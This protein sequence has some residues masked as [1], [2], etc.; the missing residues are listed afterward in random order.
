MPRPTGGGN[1]TVIKGF[2]S[3]LIGQYAATKTFMFNPPEMGDT[4]GTSWGSLEVPGASHPIQQ[5]GAGGERIISFT[6][7]VDGDRGNLGARKINTA[8][9]GDPSQIPLDVSKEL[10]TYRSLVYPQQTGATFAN[11]FPPL[12]IFTFGPLYPGIRCLVKKADFKVV[13]WTPKLEPVRAT[14]DMVLSEVPTTSVSML[15]VLQNAGFPIP[16]GG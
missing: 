2:L 13:Y 1:P 12:V 11:V 10:L 9:G 4:K 5:F 8:I 14:I 16:G 6:L 15:D 7:F 3:I